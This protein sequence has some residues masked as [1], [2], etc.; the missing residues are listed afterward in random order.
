LQQLK[1]FHLSKDSFLDVKA[2]L[3]AQSQ[4]PSS[5]HV[6]LLTDAY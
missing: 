5:E 3:Q 6:N 1:F 2:I 4:A